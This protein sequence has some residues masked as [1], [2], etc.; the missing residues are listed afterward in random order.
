MAS[1]IVTIS[2]SD[3]RKKPWTLHAATTVTSA[4]GFS[5]TD[6]FPRTTWFGPPAARI[7]GSLGNFDIALFWAFSLISMKGEK[8]KL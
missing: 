6:S 1:I 3:T 5:V 8:K 2:F 4:I 7:D